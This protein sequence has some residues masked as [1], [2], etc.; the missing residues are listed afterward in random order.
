MRLFLLVLLN[1]SGFCFAQSTVLGKW[2]T[3]DDASGEARSIVEI[4]EKDGKVYG[5]VIRI[6]PRP[7]KDPDPVCN[8]CQEDDPRFNRKIKTCNIATTAVVS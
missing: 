7:D 4:V 1:A 6:F 5:K 8:K 2:K 3:I